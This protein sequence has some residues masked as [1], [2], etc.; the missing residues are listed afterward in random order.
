MGI[1][2]LIWIQGNQSL[3][4]HRRF[5][6]ITNASLHYIICDTIVAGVLQTKLEQ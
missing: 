5:G 3:S 4:M 2:L 1:P 6:D